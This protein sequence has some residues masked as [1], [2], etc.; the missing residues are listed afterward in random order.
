MSKKNIIKKSKSKKDIGNLNNKDFGIELDPNNNL[1][2]AEDKDNGQQAYYKGS[3][4]KYMDYMQEVGDRISRGK[5]G[6]GTDNL[7]FFSGVS[8]DKN[9]KII[10]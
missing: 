7:G 2:L 10:K 6:K 1:C 5:K 8:F 9:G 3:E 4:M